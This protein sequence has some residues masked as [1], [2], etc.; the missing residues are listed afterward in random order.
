M[1]T[2]IIEEIGEVKALLRR[3]NISLLTVKCSKAMEETKTGDS[4]SVNGACLTVVKIERGALSFE[5]MNDT[6]TL[7]NLGSLN[8]GSKVN[9]E[10]SLKIGDRLSG[11][12]VTGHIDCVGSIVSRGSRD[13]NLC[14]EI[15]L[16]EKF[17]GYIAPKGSV[18]L[19]GVSLTVVDKRANLFSVYIIP[20]TMANTILQSKTP[21][22]KVNIELDILAK[23]AGATGRK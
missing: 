9:L 12:F 13:G 10:R 2:G 1:F 6:L 23:Y 15:T 19:D 7:T 18:A 11:H 17:M 5:V 4:I 20:H 3:G 21:S 14:Y 22:C 16:P 8:P